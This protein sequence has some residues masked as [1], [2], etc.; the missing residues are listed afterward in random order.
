MKHNGSAFIIVQ[1]IVLRSALFILNSSDVS[2]SN[3]KVFD[4]QS[5]DNLVTV[6]LL[7]FQ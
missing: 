5:R 3:I 6:I 1:F 7:I 4:N 2:I